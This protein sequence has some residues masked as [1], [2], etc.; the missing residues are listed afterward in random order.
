MA[1]SS[2]DTELERLREENRA[3]R[4]LLAERDRTQEVLAVTEHGGTA[5]TRPLAGIREDLEK[6]ERVRLTDLFMQAPAFIA[7]LRGPQHVFE[8]ANPPYYQLVGQ[9]D[10]IGRPVREAF[11]EIEGQGFFEILDEVYRTGKAFVGK[12]MP[13]VFQAET[14]TAAQMHYLDFVYQPVVDADGSVSGIF[15]HGVDMTERKRAEEAL[16]ESEERFRATFDLAPVGI[17]HVDMDGRWLR[18]NRRFGEISG[19]TE[20][21]LR[22]LRFQE[23]THPEDLE[24]DLAQTAELVAGRI[25]R[26]SMEKRYLSKQSGPIWINMTVS[27]VRGAE[28]QPMYYIAVVEDIAERKRAASEIIALNERLRRAMVETHHRVK[29]NLQ[30]VAALMEMQRLGSTDSIPIADFLRL[31]QNI[32]T[33]GVIHDFLTEE[34]KEDGDANCLSIKEVLG[35]LVPILQTTLGERRLLA[36]IEEVTLTSKQATSLAIV[37][38]ELV[39]NAVKHG[40]G[41]VELSLRC[42]GSM[43]RLEVCDDGAGFSEEFDPATAASTGLELIEN[44]ARFDLRGGTSYQNRQEGGARIII[45]FPRE[46]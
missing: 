24:A 11:P 8:I 17:A 28:G 13:V 4:E 5:N 14:D 7:V 15:V 20:A 43:V 3:L 12:Y 35:R 1:T 34:A 10:L 44:I 45:T 23:I 38:N 33:L 25:E 30:M 39:S 22:A 2:E 29:N 18:V 46:P 42:D 32:K 16:Q 41:D 37:V 40:R 26:F 36:A 6:V 9:R 21:E 27:L 19:Y 31:E